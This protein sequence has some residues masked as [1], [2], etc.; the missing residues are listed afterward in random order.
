MTPDPRKLDSDGLRAQTRSLRA[1]ARA[2]VGD[3]HDADDVVQDAWLTALNRPPKRGWSLGSWLSGITRNR[4]RQQT[5]EQQRRARRE[6][7]AATPDV[8]PPDDSIE[9]IDLLRHLLDQVRGLDEPY[10]STIL[11]RFFDGLSP[12]EVA[13][14]QDVPHATVR[15]RLHRGIELL[16]RRMDDATEGGR[17]AWLVP[18]VPF[19]AVPDAGPI[20]TLADGAARLVQTSGQGVLTMSAKTKVV[21]LALVLGAGLL[22]VTAWPLLSD[23]GV[24]EQGLA[25]PSPASIKQDQPTASPM[26]GQPGVTEDRELIAA[27]KASTPGKGKGKFLLVTVSGVVRT[28]KGAPLAGAVVSTGIKKG[29][30]TKTAKAIAAQLYGGRPKNEVVLR[31]AAKGYCSV[32]HSVLISSGPSPVQLDFTLRPGFLVTGRV[33]TT[34]GEGIAGAWVRMFPTDARPVRTDDQGVFRAD[35]LD[36]RTPRHY[37]EASAKGYLPSGR[38]INTVG[39]AA[40]QGLVLVLKRGSVVRGVVYGPH[41]Q[42]VAGA[43]LSMSAG[44]MAGISVVSDERGA[45]EL[46]GVRPGKQT[47]TVQHKDY[48]AAIRRIEVPPPGND[49]ELVIDLLPGEILTGVV[50]D[51]HGAPIAG[52]WIDIGFRKRATVGKAITDDQGLFEARSLPAGDLR[53]R[54]GAKGYLTERQTVKAGRRDVL[55]MLQRSARI[56]GRV[57]DLQTNQPVT[58]FTVRFMAPTEEAPGATARQPGRRGKGGGKGGKGWA[59]GGRS[60]ADPEGKWASDGV[61]EGF[62][63]GLEIRAEGYAPMIV[64]RVVARVDAR[65]DDLWTRLDAGTNL[66]GLVVADASSKPMP[67]ATVKIVRAHNPLDPGSYKDSSRRMVRCDAE[68]RFELANVGSGDLHLAVEHEDWGLVLHALNIPP[69]TP[70]MDVAVRVGSQGTLVGVVKEVDGRPIPAARVNLSVVQVPGLRG[71]TW[72]AR[73]DEHGRF[74]FSQLPDGVY[75]LAHTKG[76]KERKGAK[77]GKM[78]SL[79]RYVRIA[80]SKRHNVLLTAAGGATL[81]GKVLVEGDLP[82]YLYVTLTP[83]YP[84]ETPWEER[85]PPQ[86]TGATVDAFTFEGLRP[87]RYRIDVYSKG[88]PPLHGRAEVDVSGTGEQR[89]E[90]QLAPRTGR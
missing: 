27:G 66:Q 23:P 12:K 26:Q 88:G 36:A 11:L 4:A 9:R 82:S 87:G 46:D 28:D 59:G 10:R 64:P 17:Q 73:A 32:S 53:L 21:G 84:E 89:I 40:E 80:G 69:G 6:H 90:V 78:S 50:R 83:Q 33:T 47:L 45:F 74:T 77:G 58:K 5:R 86:Q 35:D 13:R 60:F 61:P 20:A 42:P 70:R 19:V 3:A 48:A 57:V 29:I 37:L 38:S 25:E 52:A 85:Q 51:P 1:L 79:A 30:K 7:A 72:R 41:R 15:T 44:K 43:K 39:K 65:H 31:A 49:L 76:D 14:R 22:T 54:C 24:E 18:L 68:G 75:R 62:V 8:R 55:V 34:D 67:G 63:T 2:L 81:L 16:R 71:K 56:A